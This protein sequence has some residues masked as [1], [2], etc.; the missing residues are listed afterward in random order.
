MDWQTWYYIS[1]VIFMTTGTLLMIATIIG[2]L[3]AVAELKKAKVEAEAKIT[4]TEVWLKSMAKPRIFRL[5]LVA[6]PTLWGW[7]K[8]RNDKFYRK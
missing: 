1:G 3:I 8:K 6:I 2:V 7:W 4:E 5:A